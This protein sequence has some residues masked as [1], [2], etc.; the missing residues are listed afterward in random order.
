MMSQDLEREQ[1]VK[2]WL[3]THRSPCPKNISKPLLTLIVSWR[4]QMQDSLVWSGKSGKARLRRLLSGDTR[5]ELKP[6]MRLVR[7]WQGEVYQVLVLP[8]GFEM[9]GK[10]F[11]SLSAIARHITGTQWSG[12]LF[13]GLDI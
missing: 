12:P 5:S 10:I 13:F 6:G 8:K 4:Q 2:A 7:E 1:L 3:Q 9:N 11:K